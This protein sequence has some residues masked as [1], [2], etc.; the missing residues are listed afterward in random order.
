MLGLIATLVFVG[1]LATAIGV[2]AVTVAPQ[3][4]RILRLACG[5]IGAGTAVPLE[6][7]S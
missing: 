6:H 3:W 5:E 2:I 7:G 1:A 4:E